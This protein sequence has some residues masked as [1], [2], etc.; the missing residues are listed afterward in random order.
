MVRKHQPKTS[1]IKRACILT[2][3]LFAI[4]LVL[5]RAAP[6]QTVVG[7]VVISIVPL[8]V[9]LTFWALG[10]QFLFSFGKSRY[11]TRTERKRLRHQ[12][13]NKPAGDNIL[14]RELPEQPER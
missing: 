13:K 12:R 6:G 5:W 3:T 14:G 7:W 2:V 9:I 10:E 8:A 4:E 1:I 11:L